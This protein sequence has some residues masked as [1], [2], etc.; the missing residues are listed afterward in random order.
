MV[1]DHR[2][3]EAERNGGGCW[4]AR[5]EG[6]GHPIPRGWQLKECCVLGLAVRLLLNP[7]S[8][9]G[10]HQNCPGKMENLLYTTP[11]WIQAN[12]N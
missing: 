1:E 10:H 9:S 8:A 5:E 7:C 6:A 12:W 11:N 3:G 2:Q 4:L